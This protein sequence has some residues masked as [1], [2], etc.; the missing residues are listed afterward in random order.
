MMAPM[1]AQ[2][3]MLALPSLFMANYTEPSFTTWLDFG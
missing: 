2:A 1:P 3:V